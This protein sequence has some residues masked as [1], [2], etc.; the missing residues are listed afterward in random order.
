MYNNFNNLLE[1]FNKIKDKGW[2][3]T[4]RKGTSGIG[5]TFEKLLG[6]K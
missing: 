5:I 4:V 1:E 3:K 6:K 2:I